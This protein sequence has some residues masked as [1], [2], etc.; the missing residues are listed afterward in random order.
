MEVEK[1][2][3]GDFIARKGD[4]VVRLRSPVKAV[5]ISDKEEGIIIQSLFSIVRV[6]EK[7]KDKVLSEYITIYLNSKEIEKQI[8]SEIQ[9]T[10]I[11]TI[12]SQVLSQI[13]IKIPSIEDQRETVK[14]DKLLKKE[15]QLL[16]LLQEKRKIL[17]ENF[18]S[19]IKEII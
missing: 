2:M 4:S 13:E 9:G 7:Y 5:N 1:E 11:A 19:N 10:S 12:S 18:V 14:L 3:K 15:N 16:K 8:F 6:K 17:F